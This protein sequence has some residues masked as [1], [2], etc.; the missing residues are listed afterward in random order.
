MRVKGNTAPAAMLVADIGAEAVPLVVLESEP[1]IGSRIVFLQ[2]SMA[3]KLRFWTENENV[4]PLN[5]VCTPMGPIL[6]KDY[7]GL[8]FNR[9][10]EGILSQRLS[11]PIFEVRAEMRRI[12][13]P[14]C[15]SFR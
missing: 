5:A 1:W 8:R 12:E 3:G 9:G 2:E 14:P 4:T 15:R 7:L 6:A 11:F 10:S 13:N